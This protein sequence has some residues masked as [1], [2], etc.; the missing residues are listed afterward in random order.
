MERVCEIN[1]ASVIRMQVQNIYDLNRENSFSVEF[2]L[3]FSVQQQLFSSY[4]RTDRYKTGPLGSKI[5][6]NIKGSTNV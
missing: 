5:C 2:S 6:L 1:N 4:Q 3:P